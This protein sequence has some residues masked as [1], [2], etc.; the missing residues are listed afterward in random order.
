MDLRAVVEAISALADLVDLDSFRSGVLRQIRR[1]VEC[2]VVAFHELAP[3]AGRTISS[4]DPPSLAPPDAGAAFAAFA[5]SA[6]PVASLRSARKGTGAVARPGRLRDA[7]RLDV[8]DRIAS[9]NRVVDVAVVRRGDR[10]SE[11]DRQ[12]L[13]AACPAI[14]ATYSRL[15]QHAPAVALDSQRL[16]SLGLT[17]RESEVLT[18]VAAGLPNAGVADELKI[19]ERTVAKHL[20]HVYAKLG[21]RSRTA[22][23][24]RALESSAQALP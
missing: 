24:R 5:Y 12:V 15:L 22:A 19:S 16:K 4:A 9:Q 21:V 8:A 7:H 11:R 14:F 3:Q 6:P 2:D 1:L 20:E 17:R 10:F 18:L 23:L 13:E